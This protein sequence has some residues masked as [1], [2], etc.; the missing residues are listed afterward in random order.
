M[1][2]MTT[3]AQIVTEETQTINLQLLYNVVISYYYCFMDTTQILQRKRQQQSSRLAAGA[4]VLSS[5][6]PPL[7]A[8]NHYTDAD[9]HTCIA[10][11]D[12]K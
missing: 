7:L 2:I 9:C 5:L 10:T 1:M 4:M 3:T 6:S 12:D 8:R 11:Y